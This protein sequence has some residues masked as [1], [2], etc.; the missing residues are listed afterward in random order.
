MQL[1]LF[2]IAKPI[3]IK[4]IKTKPVEL[5]KE[6]RF[7]INVQNYFKLNV[8][9]RI[10]IR[11]WMRYCNLRI[12]HEQNECVLDEIEKRNYFYQVHYEDAWRG[13]HEKNE[14]NLQYG[15]KQ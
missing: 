11:T 3:K 14:D 4:K 2:E 5:T 15:I 12:F 8:H 9:Q 7:K 6:E 13:R 1:D 10:N